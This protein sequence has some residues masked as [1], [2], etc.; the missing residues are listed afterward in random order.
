M[1]VEGEAKFGLLELFYFPELGVGDI[2]MLLVNLMCL[3]GLGEL[4][5]NELWVTSNFC[6]RLGDR[7]YYTL[8][9]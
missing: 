4:F 9:N 7:V 2:E 5:L 3:V 8:F 1:F 6:P